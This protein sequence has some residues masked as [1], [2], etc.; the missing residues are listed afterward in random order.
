[1]YTKH[2][3]EGLV[4]KSFDIGEADRGYHIFTRDLGLVYAKAKSVRELRSKLRFGLQELTH[5]DM[6]FV[7]A[8]DTWRITHAQ[9]KTHLFVALTPEREKVALVRR[10][11]KLLRRLLQ[12]EEKDTELYDVV[13]KALTFLTQQDLSKENLANFEVLL[14]LRLLNTMGYLGEDRRFGYLLAAPYINDMHVSEAGRIRPRAVYEINRALRTID[15][16]GGILVTNGSK[17]TRRRKSP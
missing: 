11:M 17:T 6:S 15:L 14:V 8:K 12:G 9:A 16:E 2:H 7:R 13:V 3:T 10:T 4:L 5:A 1:M